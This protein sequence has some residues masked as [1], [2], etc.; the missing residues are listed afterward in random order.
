MVPIP[1]EN[2]VKQSSTPWWQIA[3]LAI[4]AT[5]CA[6]LW[7]GTMFGRPETTSAALPQPPTGAWTPVTSWAGSGMKETEMFPIASREWRIKW[8]SSIRS[9]GSGV[10]Q[11]YVYSEDGRLVSLAAN[12]EATEA[13]GSDES[14]DSY[15]R[16]GPGRH[17]LMINSANV[18]W[19]VSVED[20]R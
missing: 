2:S 13:T 16:S 11:V 7:L 20:R 15:V 6:V 10:L 3:L 19:S 12:Q 5:L 18:D 8:R 9:S 1:P 4:G 14:G 17:Y